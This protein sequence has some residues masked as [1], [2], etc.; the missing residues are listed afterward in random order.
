[1]P[2]D[3]LIRCLAGVPQVRN[4]N[5]IVSSETYDDAGVYRLDDETALV[6]TVDVFTPVVD[7][8]YWYGAV[9]AANS[10]SDVYAMGGWPITVLC[11]L[12]FPGQLDPSVMTEILTGSADVVRESGAVV[13]GG[14]TI[15]DNELKFGL[16]VTGL[17]HPDRVVRNSTAKVGDQLI[18]TK[19][20]GTGL[21][22]TGLKRGVVT[23]RAL[24]D[25]VTRM[26]ATLNRGAGEAMMEI[27]VSAA[28]DITGYGF[29][30][31]AKEMAEGSG[32]T[33]RVSYSAVPKLP[34]DVESLAAQCMSGGTSNNR[35]HALP[36]VQFHPDVDHAKQVVLFDA[37]TSGG[38]LISVPAG[39]TDDLLAALEA[40]GVE[41]RA[42]VGEVIERGEKL[43]EVEP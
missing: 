43:I 24:S 26:M 11:I 18:L 4:E 10:L 16:A 37:Q 30:G 32:V 9:V 12:G 20:L 14:H 7:D 13:A 25:R 8:P 34:D 2:Q 17:V 6:Q 42:V 35:R 38:L 36:L 27:G 39:R 1:M 33:L 3:I 15:I 5:L 19:P 41:T 21:L 23:D 40:H 22:T 31:H 29:I 28:T